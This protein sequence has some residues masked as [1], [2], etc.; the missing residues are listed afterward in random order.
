MTVLRSVALAFAMF[1]R[2]PTPRVEWRPQNMRYMMAGFPLV[3][4][5]VGLLLF[6]WVA[7]SQWLSLGAALTACGLT[8]IPVAVTGGIHLDGFCDTL[9]ALASRAEPVRKCEILKDPHIGAFAAIGLAAYFLVYF[10]LCS[11]L[12]LTGPALPLLCCAPVLS[13]VL[14]ALSVVCLPGTGGAGTLNSF[15]A[16]ADRQAVRI[17]LLVLLALCAAGL[18]GLSIIGGGL[19]LLASAVC[20]WRLSYVARREFGGMRGDLAGWFLQRCELVCLAALLLTQK[21]GWL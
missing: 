19:M 15:Q 12:A 17:T 18:L 20:F 13:R 2:L 7:L 14:S 10:S 8:L 6:G 1:S 16:S 4:G 3:G 5:A 11:T 21:G 9:D